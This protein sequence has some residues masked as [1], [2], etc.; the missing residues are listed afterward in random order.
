MRELQRYFHESHLEVI[1]NQFLPIPDDLALPWTLQHLM[2]FVEFVR[3]IDDPVG[4]AAD[5][6]KVYEEAAGETARGASMR[7]AMISIVG[8]KALV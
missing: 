6:W 5:W 1:D 7:M 3:R 4:S 8:R 2:A